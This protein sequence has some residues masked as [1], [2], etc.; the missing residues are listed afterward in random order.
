MIKG[1]IYGVFSVFLEN[2]VKEGRH[3]SL[4]SRLYHL[5]SELVSSKLRK[6]LERIVTITVLTLSI[7][8]LKSGLLSSERTLYVLLN[9]NKS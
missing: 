7:W 1:A 3:C 9:L 6:R 4:F 8:V 2:S 5:T